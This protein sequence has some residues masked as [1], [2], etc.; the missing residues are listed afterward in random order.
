MGRCILTVCYRM[1]PEWT[2]HNYPHCWQGGEIDG[3]QL[4]TTNGAR[5][6]KI[7]PDLASGHLSPKGF[8]GG[9]QKGLEWT[10]DAGHTALHTCTPWYAYAAMLSS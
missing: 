7:D 9:L 3:N 6:F 4:A 2:R 10:P 1:R 8:G 5:G